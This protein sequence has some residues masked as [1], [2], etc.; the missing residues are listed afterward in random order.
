MSKQRK[1]NNQF[2][3][4]EI[5]N[6]E[7]I[8]KLEEDLASA[9]ANL[10]FLG[11]LD[12]GEDGYFELRSL[13]KETA[14]N[15]QLSLDKVFKAYPN[16]VSLFL[17]FTGVYE[18]DG[19]YWPKVREAVDVDVN[20]QTELGSK[21]LDYLSDNDFVV[22]AEI[23]GFKYRDNILIQGLLPINHLKE[24]MSETTINAIVQGGGSTSLAKTVKE[25]NEVQEKLDE[26]RRRSKD[27][28]E[29]IGKYPHKLIDYWEDIEEIAKLDEEVQLIKEALPE[30]STDP[31]KFRKTLKIKIQARNRH[32]VILKNLLHKNQSWIT[33]D[34][35]EVKAKTKALEVQEEK[36]DAKNRLQHIDE[37]ISKLGDGD[38]LE[39]LKKFKKDSEKKYGSRE[40]KERIQEKTG[41][42]KV[43]ALMSE[44]Q[45]IERKAKKVDADGKKYL[46]KKISEKEKILRKIK[47]LESNKNQLEKRLDKYEGPIRYFL[48]YGKNFPQIF[49]EEVKKLQ[50]DIGKKASIE[51][52]DYSLPRRYI[53]AILQDKKR[54]DTSDDKSI[55]HVETEEGK[56][57]DGSE[58][59]SKHKQRLRAPE[60]IFKPSQEKVMVDFPSQTIRGLEDAKKTQFCINGVCHEL[61]PF[62]ESED[63]YSTEQYLK[64]IE[65]PEEK[66]KFSLRKGEK[67]LRNWEIVS[68]SSSGVPIFV[69]KNDGQLCVEEKLPRK[70]LWVVTPKSYN[71]DHKT[72][73]QGELSGGWF[74]FKYHKISIED[75]SK[76][77]LKDEEGNKIAL[78]VKRGQIPKIQLTSRGFVKGAKLE[79]HPVY[80]EL[81]KIKLPIRNSDN[82]GAWR[83]SLNRE[84]TS[85]KEKTKLNLELNH[86]TLEKSS[87]K[88]FYMDLAELNSLDKQFCCYRVTL[89]NEKLEYKDNTSFCLLEKFEF[90]FDKSLYLP[91][92]HDENNINIQLNI[93][94]GIE[95]ELSEKGELIREAKGKYSTKT[96]LAREQIKYRLKAEESSGEISFLLSIDVPKLDWKI[97]Q[98]EG[99]K[100]NAK[101]KKNQLYFLQDLEEPEDLDLYL[102]VP[103][104]FGSEAILS[105]ESSRKNSR[106]KVKNGRAAFNLLAFL[107]ALRKGRQEDKKNQSFMVKFPKTNLINHPTKLFSVQNHWEAVNIHAIAESV[108]DEIKVKATWDVIGKAENQV[109]IIWQKN[110]KEKV[111]EEDISTS[112]ESF[113][114]KLKKEDLEAGVYVFHVTNQPLYSGE[115]IEYPVES[116]RDLYD[117]NVDFQPSTVVGEN[118]RIEHKSYVD[119]LEV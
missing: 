28:A 73:L 3:R 78:P 22:D 19:N 53:N 68:K 101:D 76:V 37:L 117:H 20:G 111:L 99:K 86:D 52:E 103:T 115:D 51:R 23:Q 109:V 113:E 47:E 21:F 80:N 89:E 41:D 62:Q 88:Y 65:E 18:Y 17:V 14:R 107:D 16:V 63:Y 25:L 112:I 39:G 1:K 29:K 55:H 114:T 42:V 71:L 58:K 60:V 90:G 77:F 93:P 27:V 102:G 61:K 104:Y 6:Y 74:N 96:P 49:E 7:S 64:V 45:E 59:K 5:N 94:A 98:L 87:R 82:L 46:S 43:E 83:L 108:G 116:V 91:E 35:S 105:L 54:E 31:E 100:L 36:N 79:N 106:S 75:S 95:L 110:E 92:K 57:G 67:E 34:G 72:S 12:I 26:Y 33:G 85:T 38:Y 48:V 4:F 40:I 81:P 119:M 30:G 118:E 84:P 9:V 44:K 8:E 50:R 13:V 70:E 56:S 2:Y 69:F 32:E 24:F 11:Q 10:D 66:Y 97:P 15:S